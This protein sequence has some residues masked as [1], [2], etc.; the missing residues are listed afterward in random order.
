MSVTKVTEEDDIV[1]AELDTVIL[2]VGR[3]NK[4]HDENDRRKTKRKGEER[5]SAETT[6]ETTS[7]RSINSE[8]FYLRNRNYFMVTWVEFHL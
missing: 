7:Y 4:Y 1:F 2:V 5:R 3:A 8:L 6:K